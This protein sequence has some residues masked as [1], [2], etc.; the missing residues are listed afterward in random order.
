MMFSSKPDIDPPKGLD[1][2]DFH[3]PDLSELYHLLEKH[4]EEARRLA[5]AE[6][7]GTKSWAEMREHIKGIF[8]YP[9]KKV[10]S[11]EVKTCISIAIPLE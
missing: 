5:N 4:E 3:E 8:A 10:Y 6:I 7:G 11:R 9:P 1:N 2:P